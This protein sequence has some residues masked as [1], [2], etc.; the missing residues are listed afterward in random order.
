MMADMKSITRILI[1]A[2]IVILAALAVW[3]GVNRPQVATV[4]PIESASTSPVASASP[5]VIVYD[6]APAGWKTYSS[7]SSDFTV[8]YPS[9]WNS[10]TCGQGCT[11]WSPAGAAAGQFALGIVES[12]GVLDDLLKTAAPY[13]VA[14]EDI[15]AGA[16]TWTKLALQQPQ[17]GNVVTSHFIEHSGK[18]YEFGT[19]SNDAASLAVYGSMIRSFTF[20]KK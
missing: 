7:A 17:T 4:S 10:G 2:G 6:A 14:R 9:D 16:N 15:K 8:S 12:A 13:I 3:R 11:G 20:L 18:I 5:L 1:I 19:A